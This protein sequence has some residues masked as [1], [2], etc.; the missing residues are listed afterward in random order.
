[1]MHLTLK[2]LE[3]P[4]SLEGVWGWGADIHVE[5]RGG[6]EVWDVEQSEGVWGKG[7]KICSIKE[8]LIIKK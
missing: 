7:N 3:V 8:N 2:R 5:T 4:G 1:M 6:E